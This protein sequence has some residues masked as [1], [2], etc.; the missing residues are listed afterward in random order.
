M[1]TPMNSAFTEDSS[2]AASACSVKLSFIMAEACWS[3]G[4]IVAPS[5]RSIS[6]ADRNMVNAREG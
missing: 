6:S 4:A 1:N 3:A 2:A 5:E